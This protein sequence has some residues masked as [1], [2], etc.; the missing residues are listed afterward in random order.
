[1]PEPQR[2]EV[3]TLNII[4]PVF[5]ERLRLAA[6]IL[7]TIEY[8]EKN[9][10]DTPY[11]LT[12]VDNGSSDDT[13][14]IGR[15]LCQECPQVKFIRLDVKGVGAAFRAGVRQN[16][17]AVVGYMDVDLS[18]DLNHI[19]AMLE[20]FK[21]PQT[22][23]VN[24]SRFRKGSVTTGRKWY[25]NI[26]SYG[27]IFLLKSLLGMKASDAICGFK[28]FR[29]GAAE[30]LIRQSSDDDGWFFII[31]MLIRAE[32]KNM[33]IVEM[34]VKW[35]DDPHTKVRVFKLACYY[36]KQIFRLRKIFAP[37]AEKHEEEI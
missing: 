8:M 29:K 2:S 21:D 14:H 17:S 15:R 22:A 18:T 1:M 31:E 16:T 12:I 3:L 4:F 28:F 20:H 27:L 36:L 10:I 25:R 9:I 6:G 33:K 7:K 32:R 34:P 23:I 5:N 37:S 11:S 19:A 26:T 13:P 35:A 24:A 30:E